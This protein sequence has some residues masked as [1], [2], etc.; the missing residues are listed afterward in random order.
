[1]LGV[2]HCLMFS[3]LEHNICS[4]HI[5]MKT[6]D[7]IIVFHYQNSRH[8]KVYYRSVM[9]KSKRHVF[10]RHDSCIKAH[11]FLSCYIFV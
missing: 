4:Y 6:K 7:E 3:L 11:L 9:I 8:T 5:D 10:T 1:M 2:K